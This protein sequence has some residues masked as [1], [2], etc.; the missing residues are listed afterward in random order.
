MITSSIE[1]ITPD[2]ANYYLTKNTNNRCVSKKTVQHYVEDIELDNWTLNHQGIAFYED[3]TLADGQHRL[4]AIAKSGKTVEM[5]VFRGLT[6]GK[7]IDQH[8]RR[9]IPDA[10]SI[11]RLSDVVDKDVAAMFNVLQEN[12]SKT[13]ILN[14]ANFANKY[15]E[16][17][18]F[19]RSISFPKQRGL[20][21]VAVK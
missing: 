4:M 16:E 5:M 11:G 9:S 18:I 17:I 8:K 15:R 3:G 21:S 10:I 14:V 7:D 2:I 6:N 1:Q 19:I 12:K 13:S 20:A